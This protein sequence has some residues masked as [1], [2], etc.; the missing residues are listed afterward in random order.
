MA[1]YRVKLSKAPRGHEVPQLLADVGDWVGQQTHGTLG[2]FDALAVEAIPKEWNP[3][4][5]DRLRRNAFAFLSLPDGSL[6]ALVNTGAKAPHAVALLGSEGEARTVANSLE[7]FLIQWSQGET[8]IDELDDEDGASGRKAL[9]SWLKAKKVKAPKAKDFDFAA[10]LDG[11]AALPPTANAQ[12]VAVHTFTPT[13]VMKKLGPKTQRLAS[14]LGQRADAPEVIAYVTGVLGKKVPLSTSE[15]NDS[16]NVEAA[17]HGIELVFSHDILNDAYPPIPKTSK[18]FIPYVSLAWVRSRIGEDVLG[19]PWKA[20]SEAEVTKLLGPPTSRQAAFADED[21][22][23]V[24]DWVY[25]LDTEGRVWLELLVRGVP[26]RHPLREERRRARAASRRHDWALRR[27]CRD[28]RLAR[29]FAVPGAPRAARGSRDTQGKGVGAREAG[30]STWPLGQPPPRCAG[31]L[32]NGVALVP[33]HERSLDYGRPQE[34]V[35]KARGPVRPRR[36]K[37]R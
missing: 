22:P 21:E 2:W 19:V 9:A 13:A 5:A 24:A 16:V 27:L 29:H 6:L 28:T 17:K 7:E 4:K 12:A 33:Q 20:T 32:R 15:N 35:R 37:A 3:E 23:T 10:W 18:T 1:K 30:A 31:A 34:D 8:E 14:L 11:D 26:H 36:A 25:S